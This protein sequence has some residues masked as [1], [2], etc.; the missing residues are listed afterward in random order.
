M[1][2]D[3]EVL[4][5]WELKFYTA[6][7]WQTYKPYHSDAKYKYYKIPTYDL[8]SGNSGILV[9][10]EGKV[11]RYG[12]KGE[13]NT[14]KTEFTMDEL[15]DNSNQVNEGTGTY[16]ASMLNN[17]PQSS[18]IDLKVGEYFD[19]VPL[20]AWQAISNGASNEHS[21]HEWHYA[22]VGG[23][24]SSVSG[25]ITEDDQIRLPPAYSLRLRQPW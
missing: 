16:Y 25:D 20:R 19:L 24:D 15:L 12:M 17:L 7:N 1:P 5:Y 6:K 9:R 22:V 3:A 8:K 10:Q 14:D 23:S 18:E 21:D 13:W 2:K 11:T 4:T